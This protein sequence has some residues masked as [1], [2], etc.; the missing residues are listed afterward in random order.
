[1]FNAFLNIF[2]IPDLRKR[3]LFT[4]GLVS[5]YRLGAHVPTPGINAD[6][7]AKIMGS[8]AGMNTLLGMMDMFS[9]GSFRQMTVFALGI[10][11]YITASIILQLLT[12]VV[13]YLEE[14]AKKGEEGRKKLTQYTRY[15]TVV[16]TMFQSFM[17]SFW[18]ESLQVETGAGVVTSPGIGFK[19]LTMLTITSGTAFI[20]WLG[21]QIT[22]KGI[23][24]GI[25]III[26]VGIVARFPNAVRL[27]IIQFKNGVMSTFDILVILAMMVAVTAIIVVTQNAQ[28][29]ITIKRGKQVIGRKQYAGN[30]SYLPIRINTAGVIPIIFASSI[31]MF[32]ATIAGFTEVEWLK[33]AARYLYPGNLLHSLLYVIL[34]IFFCYFY[35]AITFNPKDTAEHLQK[36]G[37]TIPGYSHGKRTEDY[38]DTVLVRV[39]FVGGLFLAGVAVLPDLVTQFMGIP[40][41]VADFLGGTGLI[42]IVGVALDTVAQVENQLRVRNYDGFTPKGRRIKSRFG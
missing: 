15:L 38:I 40:W 41:M 18:I 39:T 1:M 27:S 2:R 23:G 5:I 3:V 33:S 34:T 8:Q 21:E 14:L 9:G 11:P 29:R 17:L 6:A 10:M 32:P 20:M 19:L 31:L 28:R 4:L 7:L 12:V 30:V 22:E 26:F 13:P 36:Y 35:T 42:I 24:N 25:S 16:I 37:A